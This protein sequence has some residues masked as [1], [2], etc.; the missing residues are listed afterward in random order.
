M[1]QHFVDNYSPAFFTLFFFY[2]SSLFFLGPGG[3]GIAYLGQDLRSDRVWGRVLDSRADFDIFR[4]FSR[5]C[6]TS[7]FDKMD[8]RW[9]LL[10]V[11]Y[12]VSCSFLDPLILVSS[13]KRV[14]F[15]EFYC[16]NSILP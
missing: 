2:I 5:K 12:N 10:A 14:K 1:F 4:R 13:L 7:F 6:R 15:I 16:R 3:P 11:S 9:S 8:F